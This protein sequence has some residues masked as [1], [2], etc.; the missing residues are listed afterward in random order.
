ME[1]YDESGDDE[2]EEFLERD[3]YIEYTDNE[4]DDDDDFEKY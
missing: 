3:N 4:D 2:D 1:S